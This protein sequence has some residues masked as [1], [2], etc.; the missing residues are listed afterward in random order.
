MSCIAR[1]RVKKTMKEGRQAEAVNKLFAFNPCRD[2]EERIVVGQ[3][4]GE[5]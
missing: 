4:W 2:I 3:L 1:L 5:H